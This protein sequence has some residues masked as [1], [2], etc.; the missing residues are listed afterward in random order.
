[1]L[2]KEVMNEDVKTIGP[3]DTVLDAS[4]QMRDFKIGCLIVIDETRLVGIITDGDMIGKVVAED[5]KPSRIKVSKAMTKDPVLIEDDKDIEKAVELMERHSISKLP[6]V[7]GSNLVGILTVADLAKAQPT[8]VKQISS[9]MVFPKNT[10]SVA[11]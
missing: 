7:S 2:V 9:L 5:L 6:V 8:L 1:M 10:K 11:G 4:R 3:Q